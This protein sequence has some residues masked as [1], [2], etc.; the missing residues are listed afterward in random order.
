MGENHSVKE[1]SSRGQSLAYSGG[2]GKRKRCEEQLESRPEELASY[3]ERVPLKTL[4]PSSASQLAYFHEVFF[5]Y[6]KGLSPPYRFDVFDILD[7]FFLCFIRSNKKKLLKCPCSF[8]QALVLECLGCRYRERWRRG[9]RRG[10]QPGAILCPMAPAAVP[11]SSM[12]SLC[13]RAGV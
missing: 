12:T 4:I 9:M 8:L 11:G 1:F 13:V 2:R 10:M 7:F 3:L 5:L 6:S